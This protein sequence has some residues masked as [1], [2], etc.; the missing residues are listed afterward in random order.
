MK[1]FLKNTLKLTFSLFC[2]SVVILSSCQEEEDPV[3][4]KLQLVAGNNQLAIPN[5][6]LPEKLKVKVIDE[7]GNAVKNASVN[8]QIENGTGVVTTSSTTDELGFAEASWNVGN[9]LQGHVV[10]SIDS[11]HL[12]CDMGNSVTFS[13]KKI[14]LQI[15]SVKMLFSG[16]E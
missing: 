8:W 2:L 16:C 7:N 3:C 9:N 5:E 4:L 10:A 6:T 11:K 14:N 12:V 15:D 1:Y 13:L